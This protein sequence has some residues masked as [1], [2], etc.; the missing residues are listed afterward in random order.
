VFSCSDALLP[1]IDAHNA[2]VPLCAKCGLDHKPGELFVITSVES[3]HQLVVIDTCELEAARNAAHALP[4]PAGAVAY[5]ATRHLDDVLAQGVDP[6][7]STD[8]C[9]HVCFASTAEIAAGVEVGAVILE[10]DVGGLDLFFE[11]GE[12]RHHHGIIEPERLRVLDPQP[13]PVRRG[14]SDPGWRWNHSDCIALLDLPLSRRRLNA[15]EEVMRHR[16]P[17]DGYDRARFRSIL[18][19]LADD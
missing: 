17:Y 5:H 8:R 3:T 19:E 6:Q 7:R 9:K 18:D 12:A 11:L 13:A 14:W 4:Q 15:A 16:W 2:S 10:V 1:A